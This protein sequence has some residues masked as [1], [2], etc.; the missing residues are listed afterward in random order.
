[1]R[2]SERDGER[3]PAEPH[4]KEGVAALP[5]SSSSS[6]SSSSSLLLSSLELSDTKVYAPSPSSPVQI[7][8]RW[9]TTLSSNVSLPG[10]NQ[11]W[12]LMWCKFGHVTPVA[13][14]KL[15]ALCRSLDRSRATSRSFPRER[16]CLSSPATSP[17]APT[18]PFFFFIT[19]KHRVE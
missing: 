7:H 2:E 16:T 14:F 3:F 6:S 1:V 19:L 10:R 8:T 18:N 15:R 11:L 5:R 13:K 17:G 9:S 12:G 4:V